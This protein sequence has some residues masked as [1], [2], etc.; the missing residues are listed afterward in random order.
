VPALGALAQ[1]G[2]HIVVVSAGPARGNEED[3]ERDD[4]HGA[5]E[6]NALAT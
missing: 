3:Q 2:A 6:C 4:S 5:I 1:E